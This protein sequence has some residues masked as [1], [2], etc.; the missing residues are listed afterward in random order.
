M[1]IACKKLTTSI[2]GRGED[3]IHRSTVNERKHAWQRQDEPAA[4]KGVK[5][6]LDCL[7]LDQEGEEKE[8]DDG[9]RERRVER[10]YTT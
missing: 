3:L 7:I 1:L 4:T 8:D 5:G 10:R 9:W 6:V 2:G